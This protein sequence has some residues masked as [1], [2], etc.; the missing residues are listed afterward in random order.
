[1]FFRSIFIAGYLEEETLRI[2]WPLFFAISDIILGN[3]IL[4][5]EEFEFYRGDQD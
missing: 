5:P 1:M 2:T 4:P 3:T